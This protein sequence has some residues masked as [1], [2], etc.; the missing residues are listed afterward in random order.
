MADREGKVGVHRSTA[1]M[2]SICTII[3]HVLE[4]ITQ[5]NGLDRSSRSML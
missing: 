4:W 2:N 5:L 3:I 1:E